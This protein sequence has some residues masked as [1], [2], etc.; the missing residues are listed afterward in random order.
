MRGTNSRLLASKNGGKGATEFGWP[1]EDKNGPQ[2]TASKN[3]VLQ[4][5]EIEFCQLP[6]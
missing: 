4:L 2:E 6:K 5:Q 3:V 1:L